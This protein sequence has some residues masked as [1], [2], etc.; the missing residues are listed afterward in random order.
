MHLSLKDN[1]A[2]FLIII[3]NEMKQLHIKNEAKAQFHDKNK[4]VPAA[5]LKKTAPGKSPASALSTFNTYNT[6]N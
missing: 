4:K 3:E 2:Q 1:K 6:S 5:S